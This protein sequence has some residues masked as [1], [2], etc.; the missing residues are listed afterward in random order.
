M[1]TTFFLQS[2][3]FFLLDSTLSHLMKS[4]PDGVSSKRSSIHQGFCRT[5]QFGYTVEP[6]CVVTDFLSMHE[7]I[8]LKNKQNHVVFFILTFSLRLSYSQTQVDRA[9]G[10]DV[11]MGIDKGDDGGGFGLSDEQLAK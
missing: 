5:V 8:S 2:Q 4:S 10:R 11:A 3:L 7:N 9:V 1:A 6:P